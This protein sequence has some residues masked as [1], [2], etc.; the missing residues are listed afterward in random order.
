MKTAISAILLS[1]FFFVFALSSPSQAIAVDEIVS[2]V[3]QG[4]CTVG[5]PTL[6]IVDGYAVNGEYKILPEEVW[7]GETYTSKLNISLG[8]GVLE[9]VKLVVKFYSDDITFE[10]DD[11]A[12]QIAEQTGGSCVFDENYF[13]PGCHIDDEDNLVCEHNL[14][15][16]DSADYATG[17]IFCLSV[18]ILES[19]W[20]GKSFS[21][22]IYLAVG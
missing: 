21:Y 14:G 7:V 10:T 13:T 11:V 8:G 6:R 18:E 22:E 9:N 19:G 1:L 20:A 4:S 2:N 17:K 15:T 16:L 12:L 5:A 3:V